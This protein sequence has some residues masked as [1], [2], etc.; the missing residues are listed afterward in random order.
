MDPFGWLKLELNW[1]VFDLGSF[2]R[3]LNFGHDRE[4][5]RLSRTSWSALRCSDISSKVKLYVLLNSKS[6]A[7]WK[8]K[9][10]KNNYQEII[11]SKQPTGHFIKGFTRRRNQT[12]NKEGYM[13]RRNDQLD[14]FSTKISYKHTNHATLWSLQAYTSQTCY[15]HGYLR[16]LH[17]PANKHQIQTIME[18][19][20]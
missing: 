2:L 19:V 11:I 13:F 18:L 9:K 15:N 5:S 6:T 4:W 10:K 12:K 17:P 1:K 16:A 8:K 3:I 20:N 7:A 14:L